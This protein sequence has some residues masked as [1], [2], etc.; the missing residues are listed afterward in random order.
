LF[1]VLLLPAPAALILRNVPE[2]LLDVSAAADVRWFS[3]TGTRGSS[4]HGCHSFAAVSPQQRRR[5]SG[6]S[7]GF[8]AG[9][10]ALLG[11]V[12]KIQGAMDD[13]TVLRARSGDAD[14]LEEL[15]AGVAPAIE[16][17]GRRMCGNPHD[18]D[19]V[20]Q[21]T[22]LSIATHLS[23]F[24][25]RSSLLSWVFTLT[26]NACSRRRRGLKNK[27]PVA[28]DQ[29]PEA[30][31]PAATPEEGAADRELSQVLGRAL[32]ALPDAYREVIL[33]RDVE[34]LTAPDAAT[35]LGISVD[36]LKSR[37]H[38]AR[39]ALRSALKPVLEPNA[40]GPAGCPEVATLWS[41][42]LEGDLSQ[43]DCA[44]M[45]EHLKTCSACA[46]ACD[47]LKK[48]L[49]A[50]RRSATSEVRPEVQ[51]RVKAAVRAW[52]ARSR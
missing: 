30:R 13:P 25:G 33:L 21:D 52:S 1:G 14:A 10:V 44:T 36:A 20:L 8:A 29:A 39:E 28:D 49:L 17:F 47:A 18:A 43:N 42:K 4:T 45:E 40:P 3:A 2:H 51:A 19:D 5:A 15:L 48:A 22:L 41:K 46:T 11:R 24:E 16:R 50:C 38:R 27:P 23:E 32:D 34:G 6:G 35:A 12:A 9:Q 26:R 7:E 37:L 31:D